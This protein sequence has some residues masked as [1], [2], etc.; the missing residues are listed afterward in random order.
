MLG[1]RVLIDPALET[2]AGQL[3]FDSDMHPRPDN[4]EYHPTLR[5]ARSGT[6]ELRGDPGRTGFRNVA[7]RSCA[8]RAYFLSEFADDL[9][10]T[11][12]R[13]SCGSHLGSGRSSRAKATPAQL[14][15]ARPTELVRDGCG[16]GYYYRTRRQDGW[17]YWHWGR[18]VPKWWG[19]GAFLPPG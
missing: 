5:Q 15:T 19:N 2:V 14:D 9:H 7:A 8:T 11:R 1:K 4:P 16:Y 10:S 17:G 13:C 12:L 18:C 3:G 6:R